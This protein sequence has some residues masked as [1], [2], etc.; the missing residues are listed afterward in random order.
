MQNYRKIKVFDFINH[1]KNNLQ[2]TGGLSNTLLEIT[3]GKEII[4]K[5]TDEDGSFSFEDM[6]PGKWA[7][8][9]YGDNL[10]VHHYLEIIEFTVDLT[11]GEAKEFTIRVLPLDRTIHILEEEKL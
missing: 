10:P 5:L 3:D 9:I 4:R 11:A 8:K 7:I 6:R 2:D 1:D